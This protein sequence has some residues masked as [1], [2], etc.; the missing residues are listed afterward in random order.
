MYWTGWALSQYKQLSLWASLTALSL[1]LACSLF[2]APQLI[3]RGEK[4]T[5]A[6]LLCTYLPVH[7]VHRELE[8]RLDG[9]YRDY[10]SPV[11]LVGWAPK[12]IPQACQTT[13]LICLWKAVL[14]KRGNYNIKCQALVCKLLSHRI[15]SLIELHWRRHA[16]SCTEFWANVSPSLNLYSRKVDKLPDLLATLESLRHTNQ[17]TCS[18]LLRVLMLYR[19]MLEKSL[20]SRSSPFWLWL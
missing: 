2:T 17:C 18:F 7:P 1:H 19:R 15:L 16:A 4:G 5:N 8:S 10:N 6:W 13:A 20:E 9:N 12:A 11:E 14:I 3:P